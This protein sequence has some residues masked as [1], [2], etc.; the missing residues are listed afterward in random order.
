MLT[1]SI[2]QASYMS[3][4][5]SIL[6]R[7]KWLSRAKFPDRIEHC[8]GFE[9]NDNGI[10]SAYGI[11]NN[12]DQGESQDKKTKFITTES[13]NTS[14][15]IRNWNNAAKIS[16]GEFILLIADDLVPD[17]EWDLS[18][19]HLIEARSIIDGV[20][21]FTDDRCSSLVNLHNDTLLPRHPGMLRN[22][23]EKLGYFFD[24]I[25]DSTGP[26][27][28]LLI[29]ALSNGILRDARSIKFHHSI[30]PVMDLNSNVICGCFTSYR[31]IP[32]RTISQKRIHSQKSIIVNNLLRK[33]WRTDYY[34]MMRVACIN[35]L[36]DFVMNSMKS[37]NKNQPISIMIKSFFRYSTKKLFTFKF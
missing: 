23:Y 18:I 4:S 17:F 31:Y 19:E 5:Q 37:N 7:D 15:A 9:K 29:F 20:F 22:T 12:L 28:D 13:L 24:P 35:R 8:L 30:G 1:I 32:T 16:S 33:K 36:S 26:D 10:R 27:N 14:S 25:F 11:Q 2:C 6:V 3:E 34:L 21:K